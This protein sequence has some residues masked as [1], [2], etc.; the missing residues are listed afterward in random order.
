MDDQEPTI[1]PMLA[2]EDAAEAIAWLARAFGF[3]EL[4]DQRYTDADGRVSHAE[5]A[6]D[7]GRIMLATPTSAYRGPRRHQDECSIAAKWSQVPWVI[8]G[9]QVKVADRDAHLARARAEGATILGEP[10][11][12]PYGRLY[13]AEDLEGHRWMFIEPPKR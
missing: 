7:S 6:Y 10:S 9:V 5:L 3:R 11:D 8:D 1:I 4:R 12:Q 2:Y 13:R